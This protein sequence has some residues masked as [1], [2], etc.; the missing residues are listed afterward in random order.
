MAEDLGTSKAEGS[1][2]FRRE[3][4]SH[5][6]R[7]VRASVITRQQA[8]AIWSFEGGPQPLRRIPLVTEA[9][10]YLGLLLIAGALLAVLGSLRAGLRTWEAVL[11]GLTVLLFVGGW[12]LRAAEE[13]AL[14]RL[15]GVQWLLSVAA[16]AGLVGTGGVDLLEG[17]DTARRTELVW[18]AVG[19]ATTVCALPMYLRRRTAAQ[20]LALFTATM[21]AVPA[22]AVLASAN[23]SNVVGAV[24]AWAVGL[25]WLALLRRTAIQPASLALA[26]SSLVIAFAP[27]WIGPGDH[28]P[29]ALALGI[30]STAGLMAASVAWRQTTLLASGSAGLFVYLA[31][32]I[33]RYLS[34]SLGL[35]LALL[36][37]GIALLALAVLTARLRRSTT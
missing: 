6:E 36:L 4:H 37:G 12:T 29:A 3:L 22:I 8:E 34:D 2:G 13:P 14:S 17:V 10:G 18:T 28:V 27:A 30:A 5:V 33:G 15:A 24:A 19:V 7:W 11:G 21:I 26:L 9:L 16:L 1:D 35:P 31:W 23:T 20:L 25:A 32:F